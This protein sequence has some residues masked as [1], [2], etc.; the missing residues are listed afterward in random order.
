MNWRSRGRIKLG[1]RTYSGWGRIRRW[2]DEI[3]DGR[4]RVREALD[5]AELVTPGELEELRRVRPVDDD[6]DDADAAL[7]DLRRRAAADELT[8][9]GQERGDY[10]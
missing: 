4:D 5:Q 9:Q 10:D 2:R 1:N 8:H 6:C 7:A 3:R